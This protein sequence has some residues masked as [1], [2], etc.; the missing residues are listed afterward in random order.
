[1]ALMA[2]SLLV[3]GVIDNFRTGPMQ[4]WHKA[5]IADFNTDEVPD[6][7]WRHINGINVIWHMNEN[8]RTV[9]G[10]GR[11]PY[12]EKDWQVGK[13]ADFD[14][15]GVADILWRNNNGDRDVWYMRKDG[16]EIKG[17]SVA[18]Y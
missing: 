8:G 5:G 17:T 1:M 16:T 9:K 18:P 12:R 13:V 15:D 14:D 7:L 3:P 11:V 2:F 10:V 4:N 6:I